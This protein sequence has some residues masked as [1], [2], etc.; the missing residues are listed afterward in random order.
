MKYTYPRYGNSFI[1][2]ANI[3]HSDSR[4]DLDPRWMSILKTNCMG[5]EYELSTGLVSWDRSAK[6]NSRSDPHQ[7]SVHIVDYCTSCF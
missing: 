1:R 3:Q 7:W 4:P 5:S 2:I 6:S